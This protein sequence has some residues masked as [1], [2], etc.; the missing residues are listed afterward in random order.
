MKYIITGATGHLDGH[1]FKELDKLV[2][3]SDIT[4]AVHTV[5]KAKHL[6]KTGVNEL[7]NVIDAAQKA[8]MDH[9]LAM[10]FIA[11]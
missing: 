11:D 5:S 3:S 9:V 7:E 4:A 8:Q 10:D 6:E 2:P 1:I